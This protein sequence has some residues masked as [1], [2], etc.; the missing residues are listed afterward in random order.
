MNIDKK[1][2]R[3]SLGFLKVHKYLILLKIYFRIINFSELFKK[4]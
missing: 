2:S 3:N 4:S 1:M